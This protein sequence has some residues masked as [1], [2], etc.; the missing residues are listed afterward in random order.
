VRT[1]PLTMASLN[2]PILASETFL[3]VIDERTSIPHFHPS[4]S[5]P[6]T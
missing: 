4:K 1:A 5:D 2:P 3:Y 6:S